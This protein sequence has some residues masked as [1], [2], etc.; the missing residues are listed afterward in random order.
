MGNWTTTFLGLRM[1]QE[2]IDIHIWEKF[3][4]TCPIKTF[5]ELGT[6]VGGLST[7]FALQCYQRGIKFHTFDNQAWI[8]F[9]RPIQSFLDMKLSFH[10]VDTFEL[11]GQNVKEILAVVEHPLAIF[12]DD[13]DKPREWKLFSPLTEKGDYLIVHD[14]ETEFFPA[15]VGET[16]VERILTDLSDA[17]PRG[18][19]AM[20]FKR[21]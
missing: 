5:V 6:G 19:K 20:W 9:S 16:P 3:F 17:R 11:G 8:D 2:W 18:Y 10:N 4:E 1:D 21:L 14:W 7:Y 12:F 15:D 13:G